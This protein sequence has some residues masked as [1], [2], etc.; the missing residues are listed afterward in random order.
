MKITK[1]ERKFA[2]LPM[3]VWTWRNTR[4]FIWMQGYYHKTGE[5]FSEFGTF[6]VDEK[7]ILKMNVFSIEL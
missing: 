7:Y 4:V 3:I 1:I 2:W 6:A 5:D